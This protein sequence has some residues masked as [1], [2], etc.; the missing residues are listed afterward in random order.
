MKTLKWIYNLGKL[1]ERRRIKL[2]IELH[3]NS[4]PEMPHL[5]ENEKSY[6]KEVYE[7]DIALWHAVEHELTKLVSPPVVFTEQMPNPALIDEDEL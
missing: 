3:R 2:L 6:A 5:D 7:Q 4:K 1:H